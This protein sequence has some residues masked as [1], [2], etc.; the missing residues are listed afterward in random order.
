MIENL[1][2]QN[3]IYQNV[4]KVVID[5]NKTAWAITPEG[6]IKITPEK[7]IIYGYTPRLMLTKV[8]TG[9]DT[10]EKAGATVFSHRQNNISF[11][12]AAPS[13]LGEK[14]ILY[15]Y[16][17][18]GSNNHKWSDP[19]DNAS[20]SFV[21]LKPGNYT[22]HIKAIFPAG[23][24]PEQLLSLFIFCYSSLVANLVVQNRSR[25]IRNWNV[26]CG[27]PALLPGKIRTTE[28]NS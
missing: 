18:Q 2:R 12:F 4:I 3:N 11:Y 14:Q 28:N 15:S 8:H 6:L 21:E 17:L 10:L 22:L 9:P 20:V 5:K 26:G 1:T 13:F 24:Y 27:Y 25:N 7:K 16:W 23:R 19:A